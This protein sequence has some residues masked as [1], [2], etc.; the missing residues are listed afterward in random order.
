MSSWQPFAEFLALIFLA[1]AVLVLLPPLLIFILSRL[2]V[3]SGK[4]GQTL[5]AMIN[6]YA[7]LNL[8]LKRR[9]KRKSTRIKTHYLRAEL[10][11]GP[12][13]YNTLVANISEHGLCIQGLPEKFSSSR[14]F[15]SVIIRRQSAVYRLVVRPRWEE[16]QNNSS[17]AI[18]LEI[19]KAPGNWQSFVL[20]H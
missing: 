13:S 8:L 5:R 17:K 14:T 16:V 10:S 3:A 7:P 19:A 18:G 1:L 20:S 15:L 6:T 4:K 9:V 2:D 12:T 11:D